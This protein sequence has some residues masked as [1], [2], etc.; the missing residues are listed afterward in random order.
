[1]DVV[2]LEQVV[3]K[4]D[5]RV[6]RIEQILPTLATKDDLK[7]YATKEDLRAAIEPLATK[8]ELRMAIAPLATKI[9]VHEEGER[10]RQHFDAVAERLETKIQLIA[11]GQ[12]F[13]QDRFEEFRQEIKGELT[14]HDRRLTHLETSRSHRSP[15]TKPK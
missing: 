12:V 7:A 14:Q 4:V 13:L 3:R 1:M 15:R 6:R 2:E 5:D 11:E 8:E 10:T 9:E